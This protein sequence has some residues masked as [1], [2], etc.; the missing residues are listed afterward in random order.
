M[1]VVSLVL[2]VGMVIAV[3]VRAVTDQP[4]P[5]ALRE[6]GLLLLPEP[7]Q[8][9]AFAL[10][11]QRGV[12]F[13][14]DQLE[15]NWTLLFFGFA[16]CPDVCPTT[17]AKLRKATEGLDRAPRVALVTVDP[18]RDTEAVLAGYVEAF[19]PAFLGLRGSAAELQ[20]FAEQF[21]VN[22]TMV[23]GA[24]GKY[25]MEHTAHIV[26]LDAQARHVGFFMSPHK[27]DL[28]R[29]ALETVL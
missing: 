2:L 11:D 15:G 23:P 3:L 1:L 13:G 19:D 20:A 4:D 25:L 17:L 28:M 22:F 5:T 7:E 6:L 12:A 8:V 26:V 29:Q 24:N 10:T 16:S 18:A 14:P 27:P 21:H 9:S